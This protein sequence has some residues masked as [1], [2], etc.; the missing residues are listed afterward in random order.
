MQRTLEIM[1]R[2]NVIGVTSG[3][4]LGRWREAAPDRII[5]SL[6]FG[7]GP[8]AASVDVLRESFENGRFAVLGEVTT[9]YRGIAPDDASLEPY[10]TLAQELGIPVRHSR[11][12]GAGRNAVPRVRAV[13]SA[14]AQSAPAGG[15]T[16]PTP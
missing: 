13:S 8:D 3:P 14:A 6:S 2:R 15:G 10:W 12:Y 1:K 11:R 16:G 5:P 4:R 9:Q 7:G